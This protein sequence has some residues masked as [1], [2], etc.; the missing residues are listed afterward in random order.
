[1]TVYQAMNRLETLGYTF[2]LNDEERATGHIE[3]ERPP[4]AS[5]LLDIARADSISVADYVRQRQAGA[6]VVDDGCT[7]SLFDA[8]AIS[9]AVRKGEAELLGKVIFHKKDMTVSLYWKQ[10]TA[11]G[12]AAFMNRYRE[13]MK[14]AI[15]K[16]LRQMDDAEWWQLSEDEFDQM[17]SRYSFLCWLLEEQEGKTWH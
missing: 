5:A 4:E 12:P 17:S 15:Q 16:R 14:S 7:Y 6:L 10:L 2:R 8:L 11:E 1:M 13:R 3:G 9:L